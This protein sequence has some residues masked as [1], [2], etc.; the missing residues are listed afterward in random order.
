M[1]NGSRF[2]LLNGVVPSAATVLAGRYPL[3]KPLG[4]ATRGQLQG[5]LEEFMQ[6]AK[7]AQ[8]L[9]VLARKFIP[10]AQR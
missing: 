3:T 9:G 5:P 6:L 2:W 7:G 8:E 1:I 4:L 10:A